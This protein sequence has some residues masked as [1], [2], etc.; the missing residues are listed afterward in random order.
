MH[1]TQGQSIGDIVAQSGI[2]GWA[3][4]LCAFAL[5]VVGI[6]IFSSH[7][8]S[9]MSFLALTLAGLL[10]LTLGT[11]GAI[12]GH[13]MVDSFADK[14][15]TKTFDLDAGR[16]QANLALVVGGVS[17][18]PVLALGLL[19]VVLARR[20]DRRQAGIDD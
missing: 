18:A 16:E 19:G 1:G 2:L 13:R 20:R 8:K 4:V 12:L 9:R 17:S 6:A 7:R 15:T 10:P 14:P 3:A 11:V 5:L